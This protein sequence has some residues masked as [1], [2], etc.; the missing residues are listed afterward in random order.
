MN[1]APVTGLWASA[2]GGGSGV[3]LKSRL[4]RYVSRRSLTLATTRL[5]PANY[6]AETPILSRFRRGGRHV[7]ATPQHR[8]CRA[9]NLFKRY[10]SR[11]A[12]VLGGLNNAENALDGGL[13]R[14]RARLGA[15]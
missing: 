6:P 12:R 3:T 4:R 11:Q 9:D 10:H 15:A 5:L 8:R 13:A 14:V 7:G 1:S 2:S